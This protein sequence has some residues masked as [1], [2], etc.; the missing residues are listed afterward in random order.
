MLEETK[1]RQSG[2]RGLKPALDALIVGLIVFSSFVG[3]AFLVHSTIL[4]QAEVHRHAMIESAAWKAAVSAGKFL[5]AS[6]NLEKDDLGPARKAF[7]ELQAGESSIRSVSLLVKGN[8]KLESILH[9]NKTDATVS[10]AGDTAFEPS[11]QDRHESN[12]TM[13]TGGIRVIF[14]DKESTV[15]YAPVPGRDGVTR[16]VV[17]VQGDRPWLLP[18]LS[19]QSAFW[20]VLGIAIAISGLSA[21]FVFRSSRRQEESFH[22]L[23]E[24]EKRLRDVADAAGGF[25]WEV[26][27]D[28]LY[29]F[30]SA[31]ASQVI[32]YSAAELIG[33]SPFEI[34]PPEDVEAIRKKSDTIVASGL[35]FRDFEE[36]M[37]RKDGTVIWVSVNGVP[38]KNEA[39]QL[40]GYR[41]ATMDISDR[42][43]NEEDLIREKE[44]AQSASIAK[45]QFLAM[46][47]HEIRTPLNSVIGFSE[48]LSES[49]LDDVQRK[50]LD[51]VLR[52]GNALLE[53]IED[54]LEFSRAESG[55]L[56][57]LPEP[58]H[59]REFLQRVVDIHM[60]AA[61]QK[62]LGMNLLVGDN[63]PEIIKVD[64]MRIRQILLNLIGNAVKFTQEGGVYI[65]V[66][67]GIVP[68]NPEEFTLEV[69]VDDTGIGIPEDKTARL[70][71]PF[72]Q[73]DSSHTRQF[74]GSGL[75]LAI[76]K[77]LA[78]LM[79]GTV[80]LEHSSASGSRF[81]FRCDCP[82]VGQISKITEPIDPA[83]TI[84]LQN[85]RVLVVED[86][87]ANSQLLQILLKSLGCACEM[88]EN[89]LEAVETHARTPFDIILMDLQMPIMDGITATQEIR[90]RE[91]YHGVV[92]PVQIIALTANA[93]AGDR[94]RCLKA[95][96]NDY[97]SKPIRK[98]SLHK[99]LHRAAC[100][101]DP[102][103]AAFSETA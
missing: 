99:A 40:L 42:K 36:R 72:S 94:E 17:R 67:G 16:A 63:V 15:A 8:E 19:S 93:M 4:S 58:T 33:R 65:R 50:H 82:I 52:N 102:S 62:G 54:I 31:R 30:V 46:M 68:T 7:A 100:A 34:N 35:A 11:A 28:G 27:A 78:S 90:R 55:K 38:V 79:D 70:F 89:G 26:N 64:Q 59:V 61:I 13:V 18:L 85:L 22:E 88:V 53:L 21:F 43:Q 25:V 45:N 20:Q 81:V 56:A 97:L 1:R 96:M 95:G 41:G 37:I 39:G 98:P 57:L 60:P 76:S 23:A 92:R 69:V 6:G 32:G 103:V 84:P 14:P 74:G 12:T 24:A 71:Q 10:P 80:F 83:L 51:M 73:V 101:R 5:S 48:I 29:V 9:V 49:T 47:S 3:S 2:W 75:G 91:D 66:G 86:S 44:A 87:F 77:K